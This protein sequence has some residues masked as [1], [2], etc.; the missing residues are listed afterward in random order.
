[1][2]EGILYVYQSHEASAEKNTLLACFTL[3]ANVQ[4][5]KVTAFYRKYGI[6]ILLPL[7]APNGVIISIP[8]WEE[9]KG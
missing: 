2:S 1:I 9:N 8:V 5:D 4:Q 3:P 6:K 7:A